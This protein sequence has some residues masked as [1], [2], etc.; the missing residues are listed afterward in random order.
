MGLV[1]HRPPFVHRVGWFELG[2]NAVNAQFS[3]ILSTSST[4]AGFCTRAAS[5]EGGWSSPLVAPSGYRPSFGPL[6]PTF[7]ISPLLAKPVDFTASYFVSIGSKHNSRLATLTI[8]P[9]G[10]SNRATSPLTG[11]SMPYRSRDR[12]GIHTNWPKK[13]ERHCCSVSPP[14]PSCCLGPLCLPLYLPSLHSPSSICITAQ[15]QPSEG[16]AQCTSYPRRHTPIHATNAHAMR[17]WG[18]TCGPSTLLTSHPSHLPSL[19]CTADANVRTY[20]AHFAWKLCKDSQTYCRL[21]PMFGRYLYCWA[22]SSILCIFNSSWSTHSLASIF[23]SA[24][25]VCME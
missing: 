1:E 4:A 21:D 15:M 8:L 16:G 7:H 19:D 6:S 18:C 17:N 25:K 22:A 20:S 13:V 23:S 14:C 11:K 2:S 12:M 3:T 10:P 24:H 9:N 5:V